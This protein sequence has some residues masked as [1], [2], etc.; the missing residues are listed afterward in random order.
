MKSVIKIVCER[1]VLPVAP[2]GIHS[3]FN[4]LATFA[5]GQFHHDVVQVVLDWRNQP[6]SVGDG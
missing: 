2:S 1:H 3:H 6:C 4:R 5:V